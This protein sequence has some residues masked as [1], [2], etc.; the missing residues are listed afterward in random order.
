MVEE[1]KNFKHHFLL[2]DENKKNLIN[3]RIDFQEYIDQRKYMF[4]EGSGLDI[5]TGPYLIET[6]GFYQESIIICFLLTFQ[7]KIF[8]DRERT[9]I[10][11]H[12]FLKKYKAKRQE[13][14]KRH[15]IYVEIIQKTCS[16]NR[17][18]E[19]DFPEAKKIKK[20]CSK[21]KSCWDE[22]LSGNSRLI[23]WPKGKPSYS[24]IM[25]AR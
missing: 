19:K 18:S 9:F 14:N 21:F 16:A 6:K 5:L 2:A 23:N 8:W 7:H 25:L 20:F 3:T 22:I 13:L 12:K 11:Q 24:F 4:D 17:A 1:K 15:L 10:I